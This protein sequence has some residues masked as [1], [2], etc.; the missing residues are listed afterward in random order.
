MQKQQDELW[1]QPWERYDS[2]GFAQQLGLKFGKVFPLSASAFFSTLRRWSYRKF[3]ESLIN[4]C[5][6]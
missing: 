4:A 5:F 1:A 6:D 2:L 3:Q